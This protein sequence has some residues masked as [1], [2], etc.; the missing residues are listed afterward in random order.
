MDTV[1]GPGVSSN[2][3]LLSNFV[4]DTYITAIPPSPSQNHHAPRTHNVDQEG[5]SQNS[6]P[7]VLV[8]MPLARREHVLEAFGCVYW[9]VSSTACSTEA[10]K[11][12]SISGHGAPPCADARC[13]SGR[14][15]AV[16]AWT[17]ASGPRHCRTRAQTS[18]RGA[19][20]ESR[21]ATTKKN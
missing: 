17:C 6:Q 3:D 20:V 15:G 1:W 16:Q 14:T 19:S 10:P 18:L 9:H 11:D 12:T 2:F 21:G 5:A 13:T 7:F 8:L 4:K